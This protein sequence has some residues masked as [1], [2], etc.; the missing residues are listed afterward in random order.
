[1]ARRWEAIIL[2]AG[3]SSRMGFPKALLSWEGVSLIAYI[4][5]E[6]LATRVDR[7]LVVLGANAETIGREIDR[8]FSR[9]GGRWHVNRVQLL[10]NP[11]WQRGKSTSIA[12]GAQSL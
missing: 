9:G 5:R 11:A 4:I 2:A 1:Q 3:A 10:V 8:A 6:L 12:A 7:V